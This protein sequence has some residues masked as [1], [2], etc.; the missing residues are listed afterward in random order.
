MQHARESAWGTHRTAED[1]WRAVAILM[2]A[3]SI[4]VVAFTMTRPA[5]VERVLEPIR[6][7]PEQQ[8]VLISSA[9]THEAGPYAE[10]VGARRARP[11]TDHNAGVT[12]P[13]P[14]PSSGG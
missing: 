11:S 4:C 10:P 1:G 2:L 13:V 14:S 8:V 12:Y 9:A 6:W 3:I 7:I 5:R